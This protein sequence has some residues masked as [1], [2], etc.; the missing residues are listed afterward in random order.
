MS[1]PPRRRRFARRAEPRGVVPPEHVDAGAVVLRRLRPED[2]AAVSAAA[3]ASLDH[4]QPWMPW[5]TAEG[6]SVDTQQRRLRGPEGAWT[7]SS[8][9]QY[10]IFL[11]DGAFVGGCGLHRRIGPSALE[12]GYWVHVDH[13]RRGIAT[14]AAA[15]L[16]ATGF[17]VRG[18]QR[19]EIQCDE[20]NAASAAVP[21]RLGYRLAGRVPH[22]VE[23]P[24]ETGTRLMWV[25]YRRE[26]EAGA[27]R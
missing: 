26:W 6:T 1:G 10:G 7:P 11:P 23:A 15:A 27:A 3:V 2:A 25:L 8:G 24:G 21:P 16:T 13:V 14:A 5:A 9:Y 4:L 20:A 17:G 22:A 18:V 12:I 19:M